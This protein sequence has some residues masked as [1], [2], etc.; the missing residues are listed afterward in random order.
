MSDG[1][2]LSWERQMWRN[3][4][5]EIRLAA[6]ENPFWL[7]AGIMC[8]MSWLH[9]C[10]CQCF[11]SSCSS[12]LDRSTLISSIRK[13]NTESSPLFWLFH[14]SSGSIFCIRKFYCCCFKFMQHFGWLCTLILNS[15]S[16]HTSLDI[17][18]LEPSRHYFWINMHRR[19]AVLVNRVY[20]SSYFHQSGSNSVI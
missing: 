4:K 17:I 13:P 7:P 11:L 3:A 14:I 20:C 9:N 15:T 1:S 12:L 5:E 10:T 16:L 2:R 19:V 18:S 6:S 8:L